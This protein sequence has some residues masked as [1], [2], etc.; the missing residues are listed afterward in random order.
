MTTFYFIEVV[1]ADFGM[2]ADDV[3]HPSMFAGVIYK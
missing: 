1:I 3:G 2:A